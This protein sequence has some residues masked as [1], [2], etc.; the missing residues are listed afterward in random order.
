MHFIRS[1]NSIKMK[2]VHVAEYILFFLFRV[3]LLHFTFVCQFYLDF[4]R[5]SCTTECVL[6]LFLSYVFAHDSLAFACCRFCVFRKVENCAQIVAMMQ[7]SKC[8]SLKPQNVHLTIY[9]ELN[10]HETVYIS[11]DESHFFCATA[12]KQ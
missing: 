6:K 9:K 3:F 2:P 7:N 8:A 1:P 4:E 12:T 5:C 11:S 10:D